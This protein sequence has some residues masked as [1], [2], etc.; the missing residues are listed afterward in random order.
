[1]KLAGKCLFNTNIEDLK[2]I[3]YN[4]EAFAKTSEHSNTLNEIKALFDVPLTDH[5]R[6][7]VVDTLAAKT[8]IKEREECAIKIRG[9]LERI[10]II[11]KKCN[12]LIDGKNIGDFR[13][14]YSV[15]FSVVETSEFAEIEVAKIVALYEQ[16]ELQM[17]PSVLEALHSDYKFKLNLEQEQQLRELFAILPLD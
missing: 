5:E 17:K 8:H 1:M 16:L 14:N 7:L 6:R 15:N 4:G 10:M 3:C 13:N 9:D 12:G 11:I 2:S